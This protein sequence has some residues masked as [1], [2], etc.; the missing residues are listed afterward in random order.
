MVEIVELIEL[1]DV[2]CPMCEKVC[3][4]LL[5]GS[6]GGYICKRCKTTFVGQ[7]VGRTLLVVLGE[8]YR[9]GRPCEVRVQTELLL[10]KPQGRYA[11]PEATDPPR[12]FKSEPLVCVEGLAINL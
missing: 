10:P 4:T 8:S 5:P 6:C 11:R 1:I 2:T 7:V 12:D 9:R 3:G